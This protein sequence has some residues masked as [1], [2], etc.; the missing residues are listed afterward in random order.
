MYGHR[1]VGPLSDN[2]FRHLGIKS[3]KAIF[4]RKSLLKKLMVEVLKTLSPKRDL[5]ALIL[6][7]NAD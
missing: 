4:M 6:R 3:K 1:E 7:D 2:I 5:I